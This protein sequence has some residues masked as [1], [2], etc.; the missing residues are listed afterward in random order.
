MADSRATT[1]HSHPWTVTQ[2]QLSRVLAGIRVKNDPSSPIGSPVETSPVR[3]FSAD[4]IRE[5]GPGLITALGS[6]SPEQIVTFYRASPG[7]VAHQVVTSGGLFMQNGH[8]YLILANYR[9]KTDAAPR[10]E[11]VAGFIDVRDNPLVPILRGG[12]MIAFEPSEALIQRTQR[13]ITWN[14][15]DDKKVLV[16]DLRRLQGR[17]P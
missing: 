7:E 8:L 4:E 3:A 11:T 15:L 12:Y 14:Y 16:V 2:E 6:A 17:T 13:G 10:E 5:L 1:G 9:I